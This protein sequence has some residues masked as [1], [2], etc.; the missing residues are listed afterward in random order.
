MD[1]SADALG[2]TLS[3]LDNDGEFRLINCTSKKFNF[4]ERNY[5]TYE[6]E[7]LALKHALNK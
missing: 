5:L 3:Q 6:R 1:A 4:A 7:M 2:A